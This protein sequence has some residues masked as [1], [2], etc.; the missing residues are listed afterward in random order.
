MGNLTRRDL[1]KG[2]AI[3]SV[4]AASA[5]ALVACAPA[6]K[7]PEGNARKSAGELMYAKRKGDVASMTQSET[8]VLVIGGG[9]AGICAALSAAEQGAQVV[10][11]E[12]TSVLGGATM[13]SSGKI[14]AV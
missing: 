12:K 6:Q 9:G 1:L 3:G 7:Q 8:D 10:L 14:P 5:G 2:L 4:T 13:L 11:C